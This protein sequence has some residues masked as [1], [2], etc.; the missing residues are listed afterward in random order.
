MFTNTEMNTLKMPLSH[1]IIRCLFL[2]ILKLLLRK[3]RYIL[4]L[5]F[6]CN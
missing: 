6:K 1:K 2:Y 4:V 3:I 5:Y